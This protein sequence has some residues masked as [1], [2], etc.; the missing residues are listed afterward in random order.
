MREDTDAC[1]P[2]KHSKPTLKL[3]CDVVPTKP[4]PQLQWWDQSHFQVQQQSLHW[5][6]CQPLQQPPS[7][8][9]QQSEVQYQQLGLRP[10]TVDLS[11]SP[12]FLY[13]QGR[14]H[15]Y[16]IPG[17]TFYREEH[18]RAW[19]TANSS[20]AID[21]RLLQTEAETVSALSRVVSDPFKDTP[22]SVPITAHHYYNVERDALREEF[23]SLLESM[24]EERKKID[25]L[26]MAS[27]MR[28]DKLVELAAR[29]LSS[30]GS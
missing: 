16:G 30:R 4:P 5:S 6:Q 15:T 8:H 18:I 13:E 3:D 29:V 14:Q 17:H 27:R 2:D 28:E 10:Q 12:L 1:Y 25:D 21:P 26:I 23:E 19:H 24:M 9:L 7:Y 22:L 20:S 11:P